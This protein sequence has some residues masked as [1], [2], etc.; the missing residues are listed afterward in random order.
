M[1]ELLL[2]EKR[3]PLATIT[4]NR[5]DKANALE[6]AWLARMT[7]FLAEVAGDPALRCVVLRGNGKHFMAGG[8]LEMLGEMARQPA[9][10]RATS[11]SESIRQCNTLIRAMREFPKPIIASVQGGVAGSAVG[12]VAACDV[13]VAADNSFFV[14]AHVSLGASNDGM[15]SYFL[16]RQIG[17][18]K[19]LEMALLGDRMNAAEAKAHG[20]VNFVVPAAELDAETQKLAA[21]LA[22]GPTLAYGLIKA[23]VDAAPHN[24]LAA[25]GQLEMELYN[26]AA[27][28]SD[29]VEGIN[30]VLAKRP[31]RFTGT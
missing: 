16:A 22:A 29:L 1:S 10:Q 14:L 2:L 17:T 5:P 19:T 25:Q 21:R 11:A 28:S 27:R 6:V 8:D 3:A 15:A 30:A 31:A 20:L 23:L 26:K 7:A 12:L 9:Q 24:T 4:F 13:I 18:R